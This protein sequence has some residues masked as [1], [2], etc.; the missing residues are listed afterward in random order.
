MPPPILV[1]PPAPENVPVSVPPAVPV[2]RRAPP[3]FRLTV[4]PFVRD[5]MVSDP[6]RE[7]VAPAAIV[8]PEVAERRLS[9]VVASVPAPTVVAPL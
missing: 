9:P 1:R 8:T 5:S 4:P 7:S 3:P 6:P 2:E